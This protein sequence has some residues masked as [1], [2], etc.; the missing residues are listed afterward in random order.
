MLGIFVAIFYYHIGCVSSQV[1]FI[2]SH[3]SEN[4]FLMIPF[5]S[6]QDQQICM[7]KNTS[8]VSPDIFNIHF[9][10]QRFVLT[11]SFLSSYNGYVS[12]KQHYQ[13]YYKNNSNTTNSVKDFIAV[14]L[15]LNLMVRNQLYV[16]KL[17]KINF[18]LCN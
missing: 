11:L 8:C 7:E 18:L 12:L 2:T 3:S 15:S 5:F 6:I 14:F 10:I 4:S 1:E 16:L 13:N 17:V 9:R